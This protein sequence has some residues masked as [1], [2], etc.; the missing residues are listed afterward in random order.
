MGYTLEM[1]TETPVSETEI[2]AEILGVRD[3]DWDVDAARGILKIDLKKSTRS[4]VDRLLKKNSRGT[5]SAPEKIELDRYLRVATYLD[6]LHAK[7]RL[8]LKRAGTE[9]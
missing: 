7:A 9:G 5:I 2:F 4:H 8:C 1:Q 3:A 6:I